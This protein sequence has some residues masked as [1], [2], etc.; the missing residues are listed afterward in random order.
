MIKH[1]I[2]DLKC[3]ACPWDHGTR[4][5]EVDCQFPECTFIASD[6]DAGYDPYRHFGR[7]AALQTIGIKRSLPK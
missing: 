1:R 7:I 3:P 6:H 5:R 4:I 2:P